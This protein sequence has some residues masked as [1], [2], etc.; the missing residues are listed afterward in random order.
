MVKKKDLGKPS[1]LSEEYVIDSDSEGTE[2]ADTPLKKSSVSGAKGSPLKRKQKKDRS[3]SSDP[4]SEADGVSSHGS[5]NDEDGGIEVSSSSSE[6]DSSANEHLKRDKETSVEKIR[7]KKTG[8][9]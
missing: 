2:E 9:K 6:K 3:T 7:Q 1:V 5:S 4:T 8:S